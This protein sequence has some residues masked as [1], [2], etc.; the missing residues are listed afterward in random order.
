VAGYQIGDVTLEC[1]VAGE[2]FPL[3]LI[4]GTGLP[5]SIF[6]FHMGWLTEIRKVVSFDNRDVGASSDSPREYTAKDMADDT[7]RLLDALEI[8]RADV[9]GYS[10]GG[11]IAQ[12]LAIG[13]PDRVRGLVLYSTWATSDEWLKLRFSLWERIIAATGAEFTGELGA[14]DLFTYRFFVPG[15]VEML[16]GQNNGVAPR[17]DGLMRQ[18]RADQAHDARDRLPTLTHP[19][20]VVAGAEDILVPLRY[21]EELATLIPGA[22]LE[23][24]EGAAHGGLVETPDAWRAAVEPFLRSLT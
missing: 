7:A 4:S 23:V 11:A 5:G 1:S 22:K 8:E 3:V 10:L 19:T 6:G 17:T 14:L 20:L 18:W 12:E 24:I 2:G 16:R 21:S 13:Y 9:I 15:R